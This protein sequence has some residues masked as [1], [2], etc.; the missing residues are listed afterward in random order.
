VAVRRVDLSD[1]S[2]KSLLDHIDPARFTILPNTAG[3]YSAEDAIRIARLGREAGF[4][5]WVKLEVIGDERT[6]FPDTEALLSATKTL[7]KE[8]FIVLPYTNDDPIMA[9]KLEDDLTNNLKVLYQTPGPHPQIRH[10]H[11]SAA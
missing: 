8:G 1:R 2:G 6:L 9:R 11:Y 10:R 3:C 7:T 4:S 5:E